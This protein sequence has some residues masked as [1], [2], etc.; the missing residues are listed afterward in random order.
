M[1]ASQLKN[2]LAISVIGLGVSACGSMDVV[3]SIGGNSSDS[4]AMDTFG[5]TT[6]DFNYAANQAVEEFLASPASNRADGRRWRATLGEV[7]NDT[8]FK[9]DT[10][11]MTSRMRNKLINSGKFSFSGFT[12]QDRTSFVADSRQ[13]SKSSMVDQRT[14]AKAG[15]V[16]APD[17]E[18][19]GEIRQRT[20]VSGDGSRQRLE[21][22][23]DFRAVD[24]NTG[25]IAFSTLIDIKK[26][27]S[28]KKFAW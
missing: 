4:T 8:T 7:V 19:A 5:L 14:V 23:F 22:E 12:G 13:L 15:T 2:I 1:K 10:R 21:Y 9:I 20:N 17:L 16:Q 11:S 25:Q 27:G 18:I 3:S 24:A 26:L 28:N 6:E